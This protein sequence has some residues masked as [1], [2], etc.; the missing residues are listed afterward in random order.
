M[1]RGKF[2]VQKER[3]TLIEIAQEQINELQVLLD[4]S[5]LKA[6]EDAK[7]ERLRKVRGNLYKANDIKSLN[8]QKTINKESD[9]L[10]ND[11]EKETEGDRNKIDHL[12]SYSDLHQ[13]I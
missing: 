9:I 3:K 6:E 5:L 4:E 11:N 13:A 8:E 12:L 1:G 7:A 2:I 10:S